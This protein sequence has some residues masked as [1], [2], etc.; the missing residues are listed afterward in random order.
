[1]QALPASS[2]ADLVLTDGSNSPDVPDIQVE[3]PLGNVSKALVSPV[4]HER[5]RRSHQ[6]VE[7]WSKTL[8]FDGNTR[9]LRP[10][11]RI[12]SYG[13][14]GG[15]LEQEPTASGPQTK[16]ASVALTEPTAVEVIAPSTSSQDQTPEEPPV[17]GIG[18]QAEQE[19]P[20]PTRAPASLQKQPSVDDEPLH[21]RPSN[22][23]LRASMASSHGSDLGTQ[24]TRTLPSFR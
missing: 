9:N 24:A 14:A 15:G 5:R 4:S 22:G 20:P 1:M 10:L 7:A 6:R 3:D 13:V 11:D 8:S 21:T 12:H 18:K 16:T 2:L 23:K 17:D 19:S